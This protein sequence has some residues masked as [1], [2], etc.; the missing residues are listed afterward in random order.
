MQLAVQAA[1][2]RRTILILSC[3]ILG[4]I[5]F[6]GLVLRPGLP[7]II[8]LLLASY[9]GLTVGETV[10]EA[11]DTSELGEAMCAASPPQTH[12]HTHPQNNPEHRR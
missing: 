10:R 8:V 5:G 11:G 2:A 9:L 3:A 6:G 12:T 7:A 1:E 4:C